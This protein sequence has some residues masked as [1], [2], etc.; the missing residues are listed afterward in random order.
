MLTVG[1]ELLPLHFAVKAVSIYVAI[2]YV[3]LPFPS[4]PGKNDY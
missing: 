3:S 4:E 1:R 2:S